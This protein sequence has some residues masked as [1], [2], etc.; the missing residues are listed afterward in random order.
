MYHGIGRISFLQGQSHHPEA[1]VE[2]QHIIQP[3]NHDTICSIAIDIE[4]DA[5]ALQHSHRP[6][7]QNQILVGRAGKSQSLVSAHIVAPYIPRQI[8]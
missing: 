4:V 6:L 5:E 2:P 7:I 8:V 3:P 1:H